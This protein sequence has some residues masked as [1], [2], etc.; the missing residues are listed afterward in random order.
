M[1]CGNNMKKA[2]ILFN[3]GGP[4]DLESVDS[5]L[6]NLFYDK[7][8]INLCNPFRFLLAKLISSK[9]APIAKEIYSK[10]GNKSPILEET[11]KQAE[12]LEKLLVKNKDGHEYKVFIVMRYS[13][14]F[15]KDVIEQVA[16]FKPDDVVLLPLYP[17]FSSSTTNSSFEEWYKLTLGHNYK[18]NNFPVCNYYY[19]DNFIKAHKS[20][21]LDTYHK[22]KHKENLI[23]LFSAHGLPLK[24]IEKGDPYQQQIE[25]TVRLIVKDIGIDNLEYKVCYQSKVGRLKWLEPSTDDE[26]KR[27]GSAK[28]SVIIVPI[29]FVSEHSETLVELDIEYGHLAEQSGVI[30]YLRVPALGCND[31]FIRSMA[32][33]CENYAKFACRCYSG[34]QWKYKL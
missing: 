6:F 19:E 3:L 13:A 14:P 31:N 11:K 18:F 23:V 2:V 24:L 34:K 22:A 12:K 1:H 10:I 16:D 21:L 29:A 25:E 9:R 5:F 20:L 27:A 30:E 4:A 17:Q 8:I 15:A 33:I 28:K 32:D 26:I 7:N